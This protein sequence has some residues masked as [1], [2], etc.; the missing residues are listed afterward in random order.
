MLAP[1]LLERAG[2]TSKPLSGHAGRTQSSTSS[3]RKSASCRR[4]RPW[5]DHSLE[6]D[7]KP[8]FSTLGDGAVHLSGCSKVRADRQREIRR[9]GSAQAGGDDH[10]VH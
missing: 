3:L 1:N 8:E 4:S 7:Q 2:Y 10:R 9:I 6:A 5:R